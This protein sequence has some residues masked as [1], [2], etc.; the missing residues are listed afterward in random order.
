LAFNPLF[1]FSW[2]YISQGF[3]SCGPLVSLP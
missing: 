1:V 2:M 3:T